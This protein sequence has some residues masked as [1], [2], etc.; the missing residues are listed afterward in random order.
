MIYYARLTDG[1][2][3]IEIT[4]NGGIYTGNIDGTPFTADAMLLDGPDAM[5]LIVDNRCY[6]VIVTSAGKSLVVSTG[7]EEFEIELQD[8]LE[9]SS[10]AA[11]SGQSDQAAEEVKA[12]M[13][14][15]VVSVEIQE[16]SEVEANSPLVIVEAMKMQNEISALCGGRVKR[17][18]VKPGDVV[19]SKQVLIVIERNK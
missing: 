3:R 7:G 6:E 2:R 9:R 14:G 13:P 12:P 11:E 19:E 16:G 15:V 10:K 4:K 5:S 1:E 8:E 18:L 17:I